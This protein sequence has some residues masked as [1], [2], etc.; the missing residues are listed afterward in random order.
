MNKQIF[1]D[2][3]SGWIKFLVPPP[4][5]QQKN[6]GRRADVRPVAAGLPENP[7][8]KPGHGRR[9]QAWRGGHREAV[10]GAGGCGGEEKGGQE[11]EKE[12]EE[13]ASEVQRDQERREG[14]Q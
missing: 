4:D 5:I 11:R 10:S 12:E 3:N 7:E 6:Q 1:S 14:G 2:M 8:E 9:R 13:G